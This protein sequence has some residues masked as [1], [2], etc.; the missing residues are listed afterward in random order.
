MAETSVMPLR[1]ALSPEQQAWLEANPKLRV[2]LIM[3]APWAQFD[4]R[5]NA[6]S[7]AN[8][9]LMQRVLESIGVEPIWQRYTDQ[10]ALEK[11][12]ARGQVDLAPGLQQTP[13]GLRRWDFSDPYMRVPHMVVGER[14]ASSTVDLD[15]V[16]RD[17]RVALRGSGQA[18]EYLRT[19]HPHLDLHLVG[20]DRDAMERVLRQEVSYA[21][22]DEAQLSILLQE[23]AFMGL[24]IVGDTG[25]SQLLRI[26][27]RR[28]QPILGE[29]I[30]AV[31]QAYPAS[32]L[33]Q[34]HSKWMPLNSRD[35]GNPLVFWRSFSF[36]LAFALM[37]VGMIV[38][39]LLRQRRT[40]ERQ[41]ISARTELAQREE[42]AQA[43]RL[44]QF[45]IDQST[46]GILWV[47]WDSHVRYANRAA[48]RM[49][50]YG[51]NRLVDVP[52]QRLDAGMSMDRWLMLW[53][54]ARS[55]ESLQGYEIDYIQADGGRL[56]VEISLSFLRFGM[57]E[58]L[59]VFLTDITERR[60]TQAALLESE[61]RLK[62]IAGNVPGLVFRLERLPGEDAVE[63]AY[64]SEASRELVGY[65]PEELRPPEKG[66]RSLVHPD[67][68]S[69]Y[70]RIQDAAFSSGS[71]WRWQGRIVT[72]AGEIRW[73]DIKATTRILAEG[74]V[75]WDGIV[76]DITENKQVELELADSRA[77]LRE[78]A[79]H[80]E[81]VRE[82]EKARIAREVHDE[83]GQ[84]L[85]VLKLET[86]M[87]E[88]AFAGQVQGLDARLQSM[89]RLIAQLFQ[90]VRDVATALRPPILDAGIASAI[91]WQVRRFEARTQIPCM[92]EV[93]EAV[94]VIS[95]AKA[96][97]LFRILQEA[98]TNVMRHA[99]AHSVQVFLKVEDGSLWLTITDDGKGFSPQKRQAGQS[100]GLVGMQERVFMLGGHL[101]IDSE[102]GEGT[103]LIVQVPLDE[104]EIA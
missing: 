9:E 56:P 43:L 54:Q 87:C 77:R 14:R 44:S 57:S 30:V 33:D 31:L 32:E 68:L 18:A 75:V 20:S 11:A 103:T 100:F 24:S 58:Y 5:E 85:T 99:H 63:F 39:Y 92:A 55:S 36:F 26:A 67:D 23:P 73:A 8:V 13:A 40:L 6:L 46:V 102:P 97:G 2:G 83:L 80:L 78:L 53:R 42:A 16:P 66:I 71:D 17:E 94:P 62:G 98:L 38:S 88:L 15:S 19:T 10:A 72:R 90:L 48:E 74:V 59:V 28:D 76:W 65:A 69:N 45:S 25:L 101:Q 50:G 79:A 29:I 47:N 96:I 64:I 7:G 95:D 84:V 104:E 12:I 34:L 37:G 70:R 22:V 93:P 51:S 3:Q 4:R 60:K 89:K 1:P 52:L 81:S 21:V 35:Q 49:L 86:A 82:E 41:L 27:T 91:E 61:A